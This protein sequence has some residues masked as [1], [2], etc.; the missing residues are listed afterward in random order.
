MTSLFHALEVEDTVEIK[1]PLGLFE[2]KGAG[3]IMHRGIKRKVREI[4]MVCAGS[5]TSLLIPP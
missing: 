3:I 5:G 1:G 2:W 4:G